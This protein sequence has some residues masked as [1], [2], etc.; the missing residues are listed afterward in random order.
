MDNIYK[1]KIAKTLQANPNQ[2]HTYWKG[3]VGLY[4][5][6]KAFGVK[7][8]D[9]IIIPAFTCVVV[10]NAIIYLG[11]KPI[12]VDIDNK[13]YNT[14]LAQIKQAVTP[15]TKCIV[16]QNTFGLSSQVEE[17]IAFAKENNILTIEDC[18]HGFGG[19]YNGNPNG[20][21]ADASFFSTQWNKPFSTGIGGF[22]YMKNKDY[23][24]KIT[25][26]NEELVTPS[27]KEVFM[28][29]CLFFINK[30]VVTPKT[31]WVLIKLY[32]FLSKKGVVVGSSTGG[33]ISSVIE[34]ANYFKG[35]SKFQEKLGSKKID[36]TA[37]VIEKRIKKALILND[38]LLKNNKKGVDLNLLENHSFLKFPILVTDRDLFKKNAEKANIKLGDWFVS[39]IHPI[40]N[41]FEK[42]FLNPE[43]FPV[44]KNISN[45]ILNLDTDDKSV[46]K[47]LQFLTNNLAYIL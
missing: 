44:A 37:F 3:R 42:W 32:R 46:D 43:D 33:E 7:N 9:E 25:N 35:S 22:V 1:N 27:F 13:T 28:L 38:F 11:A 24:T 5:I 10:P 45:S 8:N 17:I 29:R 16:I 18:T 23:L 14:T 4:A 31:Y 15:K 21:Y 6:L 20:I 34:P 39:M 19:E 12:Y 26:L 30:Y 2:I 41:D 47:T 40:E 36:K